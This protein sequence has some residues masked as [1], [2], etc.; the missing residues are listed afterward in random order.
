[1][2]LVVGVIIFAPQQ[3]RQSKSNGELVAA[4]VLLS[5]EEEREGVGFWF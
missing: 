4:A 2:V 1:V 3:A 5:I